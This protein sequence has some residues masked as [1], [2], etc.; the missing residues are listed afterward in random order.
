MRGK[1]DHLPR[2]RNVVVEP[3]FVFFVVGKNYLRGF[4]HKAILQYIRQLSSRPNEGSQTTGC[5]HHVMK[6]YICSK[7]NVKVLNRRKYCLRCNPNVVNW[8]EVTVKEMHEKRAYQR[9]SRIRDL[10]RKKYLKSDKPKK[11][12]VC[13]YSIFFDVCHIK[14]I[15]SYEESATLGEINS[16]DNL[17]ALCKIHHTEY[18]RGLL[19]EISK[20][21]K[22]PRE[23]C[24]GCGII[25]KSLVAKY[26]RSCATKFSKKKKIIWPSIKDLVLLTCA[27]SYSSVAKKLE[28]SDVAVKKHI[29]NDIEYLTKRNKYLEELLT[30]SKKMLEV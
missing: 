14:D 28:V 10:S 21:L 26:C 22:L 20:S 11:C 17:M 4:V 30:S 9:N 15:A 7:C 24:E 16:L 27:T 8:D 25:T 19:N 5:Y 13:G 2:P 23:R 18:D 6:D 1:S 3:N 12:L 29:R